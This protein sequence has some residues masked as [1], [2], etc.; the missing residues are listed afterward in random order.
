MDA[1]GKISVIKVLDQNETPGLGG[2]VSDVSF[3]SRFSG[4]NISDLDGI[5]AITGAT[6]S[7]RAVIDSVKKKAEVIQSLLKNEK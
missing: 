2:M 5:Q 3:T 7:S 4:K 1:Q 6:I